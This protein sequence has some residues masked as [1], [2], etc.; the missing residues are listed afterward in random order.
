MGSHAG[1]AAL[2]LFAAWA[3]AASPALADA[4]GAAAEAPAESEDAE[5]PRPEGGD[6]DAPQARPGEA[7]RMPGLTVIGSREDERTLPGSGTYLGTEDFRRQRY[8]D[9]GQALRQVPGVYVRQEDGFGLFPNLSLRGVD[10]TRSAKVT[11]MEDGVPTAPAPYSAPSAYYRPTLGRMSGLEVLKGSS[12]IR[13]GPHTTG[14]VINYLSTPIPESMSGYLRAIYGRNHEVRT[15][16]YFGDTVETGVGEV[17]YLIEGFLRRTDGFKRIDGAPDFSDRD[18]TGFTLAEPMLKLSWKPDTERFQLFEFKFGYTELDA[19]ETYLGLS[20]EDFGDDPFRRYSSTRYDNI[21]TQHFRTYLRHTIDAGLG[22]DLTTTAY[23]N[24][25]ERNWFK[26]SELGDVQVSGAA[27]GTTTSMGLS[28]ALA[29]A[30]GGLGLEVLKGQREGTLQVTNNAREYY[31]WGAE[32]VASRLFEAGPVTHDVSVG[33][34]FHSDQVRRDQQ[35]EFFRQDSSGRIQSRTFGPPGG[36]GNREQETDAL[37]VFIEDSIEWGRFTFR[38]GL[39]YEHLWVEYEDFLSGEQD[40]GTLDVWAP[41]LGVTFDATE[42]WQVFGGV[43]RGFSVPAPRAH[44]RTGLDEE[45]SL[46]TELGLRYHDAEKALDASLVGFYTAFDDL[47]VIDNI[48]GTGTGDSENVGEV[49]SY[50]VELAMRFDPAVL[51]DC[52]DF[53]TPS[54]LNFTYTRARLD[55]DALSADPDSLFSG[56]EDGNRVPYVPD[57]VVSFGTGLEFS[58]FGFYVSASWVDEAFTTASNTHRQ[59]DVAGNPDARFGT[60]DSYFLVDLSAKVEL[61]EG[62]SLIGGIHNVFDDEYVASRHPHGPRPGQPRFAYAGL[63]LEF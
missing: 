39:R 1:A 16:A 44:L 13:Y 60:T 49:E 6:A 29:G 34:R 3:L 63:E 48:G 56:G 10:T 41:G 22:V 15:H 7:F 58:R 35:D 25:F 28:E 38:P 42:R 18:D 26:L 14:G 52:D 37:A 2:A 62:V 61:R 11:I 46:S 4:E 19:E 31:L 50:G 54:F 27:L 9:V 59:F 30:N 17:G 32:S 8:D 40:E 33:V 55:G 43:Y 53:R 47:I 5:E 45:T 57:F 36:A 51:L 21:Q 24:R 23:Y 12:Q 20:E